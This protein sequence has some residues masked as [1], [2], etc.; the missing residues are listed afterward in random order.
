[1]LS[2][3]NVAVLY[4]VSTRSRQNPATAMPTTPAATPAVTSRAALFIICPF[5]RPVWARRG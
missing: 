2:E 5:P 1:M 4:P 3:L